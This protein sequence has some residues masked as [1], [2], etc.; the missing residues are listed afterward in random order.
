MARSIYR[1][2]RDL[3]FDVQV[4]NAGGSERPAIA[5]EPPPLHLRRAQALL[6]AL[7]RTKDW[8]ASLPVEVRPDALT[9]QFARISNATCAVWDRPADCREY[10]QEL[11]TDRRGGRAGFP[12]IVVRELNNLYA[13]YVGMHDAINRSRSR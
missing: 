8:L 13:Y 7:P 9:T 12:L 11:L 1:G 2:W 10:L 4:P 5:P 3:P 6:H